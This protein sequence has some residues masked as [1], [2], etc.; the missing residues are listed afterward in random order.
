MGVVSW[1]SCGVAEIPN[2]STSAQ[3]D[4]LAAL[5]LATGAD[6]SAVQEIKCR[7]LC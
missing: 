6:P 1:C 3:V 7:R 4:D 2:Y 5:A